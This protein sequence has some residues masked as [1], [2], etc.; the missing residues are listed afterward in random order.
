ME[1]EDSKRRFGPDFYL[2]LIGL[3]VGCL[4][5]FVW[6]PL[7]VET[8]IVE[9]VRG[10][11]AIGDSM[12]PTLAAFILIL[13]GVLSMI[14]SFRAP[15]RIDLS[16]NSFKYLLL[17][18]IMLSISMAVIR[19]AGPL[20]ADILSADYRSLRDTIP[21]KYIGFFMGGGFMV[22]GLISIMEHRMRWQM[23]VLAVVAV[24]VMMLLYDLPFD[25]LQLPPN[26][27][28]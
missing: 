7:D 4:I 5:I 13:G 21:W 16:V 12:A 25:N 14:Q 9:K 3:A 1:R 15:G 10:R 27:D 17:L 28:L 22:F 20:A 24:T 19:W 8:G 6:I 18:L 23:L 2:G 11:V 26:G